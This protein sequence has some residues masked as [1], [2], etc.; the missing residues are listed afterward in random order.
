MAESRKTPK[1]AS[2]K[3]PVSLT[4]PRKA[5]TRTAP[6]TDAKTAP[7]KA[8]KAKVTEISS[9]ASGI[10]AVAATPYVGHDQ[11]AALAHRIWVERGRRQGHHLEDWLEAE[12][13]L[14]A[15]AS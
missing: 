11:I 2:E 8:T 3:K 1:A 7:K 6:E 4:S 15:K 5:A 9:V 10:H 13:A 12:R 14:R